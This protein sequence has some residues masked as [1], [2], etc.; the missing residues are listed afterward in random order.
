KNRLKMKVSLAIVPVLLLIIRN[1]TFSLGENFSFCVDK[2]RIIVIWQPLVMY[3]V[4]VRA[5]NVNPVEVHP[6]NEWL[7][8]FDMLLREFHTDEC[9]E[10]C[11]Y[12]QLEQKVMNIRDSKDLVPKVLDQYYNDL[13]TINLDEPNQFIQQRPQVKDPIKDPVYPIGSHKFFEEE[14]RRNTKGMRNVV[15]YIAGYSIDDKT[16]DAL[17]KL[18]NKKQYAIILLSMVMYAPNFTWLSTQ[19]RNLWYHLGR[20]MEQFDDVRNI[21]RNP[22]Y[23]GTELG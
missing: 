12:D 13:I 7:K 14:L 18:Q 16:T 4:L 17:S 23:K 3:K 22:D 15:L 1:V 21:L 10:I 9:Y 19:R 2:T 11:F 6:R 20:H 8:F 5:D